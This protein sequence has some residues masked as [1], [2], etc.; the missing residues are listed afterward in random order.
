MAFIKLGDGYSRQNTR[1]P[2]KGGATFT[3]GCRSG[4]HL[5][6]IHIIIS[7]IAFIKS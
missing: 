2:K 1:H 4:R 3:K 5:N 6:T 7:L